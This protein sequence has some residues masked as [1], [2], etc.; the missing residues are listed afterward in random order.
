[1]SLQCHCNFLLFAVTSVWL[2]TVQCD[3]VIQFRK[4]SLKWAEHSQP[5]D[6]CPPALQTFALLDWKSHQGAS[7]S[8]YTTFG[9]HDFSSYWATQKDV[10]LVSDADHLCLL[11]ALCH[12]RAGWVAGHFVLLVHRSETS[13]SFQP[14]S[15][16]LTEDFGYFK[17]LFKAHLFS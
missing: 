1:M 8:S 2:V 10:Q 17:Q 11:T 7:R 5:V 3:C 13:F 9:D 16:H 4:V 12:A 15:T 6:P 14:V